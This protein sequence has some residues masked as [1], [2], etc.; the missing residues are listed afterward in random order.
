MILTLFCLFGR[1]RADRRTNYRSKDGSHRS[2]CPGCGKP[3]LLN[4][5]SYRWELA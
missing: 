3:V 1:H 2:T 5:Q 4:P